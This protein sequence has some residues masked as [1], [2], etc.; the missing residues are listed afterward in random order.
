MGKAI[1][2]NPKFVETYYNPGNA[3]EEKGLSENAISS[4]AKVIEITPS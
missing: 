2:V 1:I 3:C 4:W